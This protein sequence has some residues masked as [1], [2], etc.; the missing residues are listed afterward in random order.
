MNKYFDM[1][2]C[3]RVC[4]SVCVSLVTLTDS[5]YLQLGYRWVLTG[6]IIV[7]YYAELCLPFSLCTKL[8]TEYSVLHCC[9][10]LLLSGIC[11]LTS[12]WRVFRQFSFTFS[13]NYTSYFIYFFT[14]VNKETKLNKWEFC[15][16]N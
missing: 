16:L 5:S 7:K 4:V 14:C 13:A 3:V 2:E 12:L 15:F 11:H 6:C 9:N 1:F 10:Y 8:H